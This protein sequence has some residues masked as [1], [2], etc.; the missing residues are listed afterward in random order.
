MLLKEFLIQWVIGFTCLCIRE[1]F[2]QWIIDLWNSHC[3][4]CKLEFV[5]RQYREFFSRTEREGYTIGLEDELYKLR[6]ESPHD[7]LCWPVNRMALC[8]KMRADILE[9][10]VLKKPNIIEMIP[11]EAKTRKLESIAVSQN[12]MLLRFCSYPFDRTVAH[13]AIHQNAFAM[14]RIC[15]FVDDN[16]DEETYRHIVTDEICRHIIAK[17]DIKLLRYLRVYILTPALELEI[18]RRF[19]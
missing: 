13:T 8:T 6:K 15:D 10:C 2:V 18:A 17:N 7:T 4:Q 14:R 3:W 11:T 9:E 5:G 1:L 19:F 16:E 12:G